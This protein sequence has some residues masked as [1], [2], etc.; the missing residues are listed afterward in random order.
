MSSTAAPHVVDRPRGWS[1]APS[2]GAG[3]AHDEARGEP[4]APVAV[5]PLPRS[6]RRRE[7]D[8][9]HAG[10][11]RRVEQERRRRPA[12]R[13]RRRG[14]G[15]SSWPGPAAALEPVEQR[16]LPQRPVAVEPV[17]PEVAEPARAARP[18]RPGRGASRGGRG[19]P[20]RAVDPLPGE[21]VERP[22]V[23]VGEP[24]GEARHHAHA[25]A[26]LL[27]QRGD[28]G[29]AAV[30]QRVEDE[31]RADVHVRRHVLLLELE[32][33]RVQ[34]RELLGHRGTDRMPGARDER[35]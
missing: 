18:R 8:G 16:D 10:V 21:P 17:G 28:V 29:H 12:S 3:A 27:A 23:D 26:H 6:R 1:A 5:L 30:R 22:R 14:S 34:H 32:E 7:R 11:G 31:R 33:H 2:A 9:R 35:P 19:P 25:R 15:G 24:L 4:E 20:C 13:R